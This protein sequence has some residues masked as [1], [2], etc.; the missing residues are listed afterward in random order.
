M[1]RKLWVGLL[2]I[3]V[4]FMMSALESEG[5]GIRYLMKMEQYQAFQDPLFLQSSNRTDPFTNGES[6]AQKG[7]KP[8]LSGER[9]AREFFA[10]IGGEVVGAIGGGVL[11]SLFPQPT[12]FL[13]VI[14]GGVLGGSIGVYRAGT[15]NT[16]GGSYWA[17]LGGYL[18]FAGAHILSEGIFGTPE[19]GALEVTVEV[20][21]HLIL[22]VA[23]AVIGFNLTR[24]YKSPPTSG[25]ALINFRDAQM[26]LAVPTTSFRPDPYDRGTLTQRVDLVKVR[27]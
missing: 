5:Q 4:V 10:G 13:G 6:K 3:L 19:N 2:L 24:R 8:S 23:G 14:V 18:L 22:P 9:I 16:H 25:K 27:F 21:G 20:T 17:T 26:R 11:G 12:T 1:K 7:G 15:S